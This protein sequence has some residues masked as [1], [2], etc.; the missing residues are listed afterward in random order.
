M[1]YNQQ[2]L[3]TE[4]GSYSE[5]E[6]RQSPI[7]SNDDDLDWAVL[8]PI[9]GLAT[10]FVLATLVVIVIVYC[11]CHSSRNKKLVESPSRDF[12]VVII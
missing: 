6:R 1:V 3:Y 7:S 4:S 5:L 9:V 12:I 8:G 2:T 11:Y 10:V